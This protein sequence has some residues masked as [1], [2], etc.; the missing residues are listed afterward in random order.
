[1][2][3]AASAARPAESG[4]IVVVGPPG[5]GK[6]TIGRLLADRLGVEFRDTDAD[7]ERQVGKAVS[8]IFL[9]DGEERF[10]ELER[11][12]VRAALAEHGG[13]L[14][15]GGGAI[16]D[17]DTRA[18]L[19]GPRVI[20]LD[21]GLADAAKRVGMAH[22]RP[23][24]VGNPRTMLRRQLEARRPLYTE[25]ATVTVSTD[26]REP[27]EIADE[28]LAGLDENGGPRASRRPAHGGEAPA[29][30]RASE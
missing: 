19:H 14:A 9:D 3:S 7:V 11:E 4:P 23:L 17:P 5:S 12:A 8:D 15:L 6:T 26:G 22:D 27:A 25:V 20:F 13:V 21:V 24:L 2:T 1:M 16:Q 29:S 10:R 30:G 28:A 18:D